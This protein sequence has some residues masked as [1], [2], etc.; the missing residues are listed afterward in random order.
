MKGAGRPPILEM[1]TCKPVGDIID[2]EAANGGRKIN[3]RGES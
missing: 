3:D 1:P 2:C